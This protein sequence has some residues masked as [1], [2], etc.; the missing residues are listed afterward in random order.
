MEVFAELNK[1]Q[2]DREHKALMRLRATRMDLKDTLGRP[3]P[4]YEAI[5]LPLDLVPD[6][7]CKSIAVTS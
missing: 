2:Q 6:W 4:F 3:D 1:E 5:L 7:T